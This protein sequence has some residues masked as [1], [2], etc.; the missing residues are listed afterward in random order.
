MN[1][2]SMIKEKQKQ[3]AAANNVATSSN[4][5]GYTATIDDNLFRAMS[6]QTYKEIECGDGKELGNG[7]QPG[8]I[9]ALHSSSALVVNVFD[10]WR[11]LN[12]KSI[13]AKALH[14]PSTE[15]GGLFFEKKYPI[16]PE[17]II[18]PNIDVVFEYRNDH[19]CATESKF[20]EP[21]FRVGEKDNGLNKR[22]LTEFSD[23][24]QIPSIHRLA[25]KISPQNNDFKYLDAAQLIKHILGL[26]KHYSNN[27]EKFRLVYLYYAD[28]DEECGHNREVETFKQEVK[29]DK[30]RFQIATWQKVL[31]YLRKN[32]GDAH[33][34]YTRYLSWRYL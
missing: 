22:Y 5:N 32:L 31:S 25:Q 2:Y 10:Y 9:Q 28:Q 11:N 21:Y 8:N 26:L 12:D 3:W 4:H 19:C 34:D 16:L 20:S 29:K 30:I 23:W 6:H 33:A 13:L 18:P 27:K 17:P 14:L 15:I 7:I 24:P 1:T